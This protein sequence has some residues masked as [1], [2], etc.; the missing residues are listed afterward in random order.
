WFSQVQLSRAYDENVTYSRTPVGSII[1]TRSSQVSWQNDFRIGPDLLQAIVERKNEHAISG[2][3]I[4]E[5]RS[6]DSVALAYQLQRGAH[7]GN[8]SVR[9]DDNSAYGSKVTGS[10]GY[11]YRFS[12][13]LRMSGSYGTSFRAPT[14]NELYFPGSGDPNIKPEEGRNAEMGI[15]YDDGNLDFSAAYYRNRLKNLIDNVNPC[16]TGGSS[17]ARNVDDALLQGV[18]SSI[19]KRFGNLRVFGSLDLQNPKNLENGKLLDRRARYHGSV[20]MRYAVEKYTFGTDVTFSG[21]RYSDERDVVMM[22]G[23]ALLNFQGTYN[24]N[25]DWQLFGRWNNALEKRYELAKN[26]QTP[27]SNVFVGVLYGFH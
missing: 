9:H 7:M 4:D 27:G 24:L 5:S 8:A 6:T 16:P 14:F 12:N 1:R 15:Y 21:G 2:T 25:K 22:G 26:Y 13:N 11:G 17:C 20:G 3:A 18:T 10:V 23:Y 19:G